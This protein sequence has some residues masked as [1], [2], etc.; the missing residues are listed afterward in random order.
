MYTKE[1][2]HEIWTQL[3]KQE[4]RMTVIPVNLVALEYSTGY[5]TVLQQCSSTRDPNGIASHVMLWYLIEGY[6]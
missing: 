4:A 3:N 1:G 6:T 2:S 5:R